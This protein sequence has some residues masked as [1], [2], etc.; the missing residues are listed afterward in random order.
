MDIK[1][2]FK[3]VRWNSYLY[4]FF[5]FCHLKHFHIS[6]LKQW[7]AFYLYAEADSLR[8]LHMCWGQ[9]RTGAAWR[10][11][12]DSHQPGHS[13]AP[14]SPNTGRKLESKRHERI[15]Y[16]NYDGCCPPANNISIVIGLHIGL[17]ITH[18]RNTIGSH[19]ASRYFNRYSKN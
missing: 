11:G 13:Q 18:C 5:R 8:Q 2:D 9:A 15:W 7:S 12:G 3:K 19:E 14:L 1:N 17:I 6:T 10:H 16:D 4:V